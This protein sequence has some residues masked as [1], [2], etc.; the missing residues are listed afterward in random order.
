MN[1]KLLEQLN[2]EKEQAQNLRADFVK[3]K[4]VFVVG[5]FGIGS[6]NIETLSFF[7]VLFI[8]PFISIGFD[9]YILVEDF[10]VK[11][12]GEFIKN[13]GGDVSEWEMWVA[14]HKNPYAIWAAPL[15]TIITTIGSSLILWQKLDFGLCSNIVSS[16]IWLF[17][18]I[19]GL[20]ILIYK[21]N[22]TR[23]YFKKK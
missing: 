7:Q 5:L 18:I 20:L 21:S 8:I 3:R 19:I 23:E 17:I 4:L 10:K 9:I 11:R 6:I 1:D 22:I 13:Q 14:S 16:L 12:I 2:K 15:F